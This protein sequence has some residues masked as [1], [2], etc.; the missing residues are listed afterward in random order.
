MPRRLLVARCG[1]RSLTTRSRAPW[2]FGRGLSCRR[3]ARMSGMAKA[4]DQ[5]SADRLNP[6]LPHQ[7]LAEPFLAG[8]RFREDLQ[9]DRSVEAGIKRAVDLTHPAAPDSLFDQVAGEFKA[10]GQ[11]AAGGPRSAILLHRRNPAAGRYLA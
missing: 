9:R 1:S 7:A 10:K 4:R 8:K 6:G 3:G 11:G 2:R 5:L